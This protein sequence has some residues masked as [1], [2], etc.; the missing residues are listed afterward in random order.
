MVTQLFL[1]TSGGR[2]FLTKVDLTVWVF[3]FSPTDMLRYVW[4]HHHLILCVLA[5]FYNGLKDARAEKEITTQL[6]HI[7]TFAMK[8]F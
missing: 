6:N 1:S 3:T 5:S 7:R 2:S 4:H 8:I